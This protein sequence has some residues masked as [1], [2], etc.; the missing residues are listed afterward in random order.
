M[1]FSKKTKDKIKNSVRLFFHGKA[2]FGS[3][4]VMDTTIKYTEVTLSEIAELTG[5]NHAE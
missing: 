2:G 4:E 3:E 5:G 1:K